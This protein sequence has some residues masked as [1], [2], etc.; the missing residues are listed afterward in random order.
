MAEVIDETISH[1]D[2][3]NLYTI[4]FTADEIE[5]LRQY[6]KLTLLLPAEFTAPDCSV[7][8]IKKVDDVCL[9]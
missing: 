2:D 8:L 7:S 1:P 9:I 4:A 3:N 5:Y 6:L